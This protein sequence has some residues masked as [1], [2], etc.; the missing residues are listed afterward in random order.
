MTHKVEDLLE[1]V[2]EG[3]I[4]TEIYTKDYVDVILKAKDQINEYLNRILNDQDIIVLIGGLMLLFCV[5]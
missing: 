1:P 3:V 5:E 2:R 4:D